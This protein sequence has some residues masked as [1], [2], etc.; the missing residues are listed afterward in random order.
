MPKMTPADG[1]SVSV[2]LPFPTSETPDARLLDEGEF[3]GIS[4]DSSVAWVDAKLDEGL[5]L[6][7]SDGGDAVLYVIEGAAVAF[8]KWLN[9]GF[10]D[11]ASVIGASTGLLVGDFSGDI[12]GNDVGCRE[13]L[14]DGALT[15]DVDG[16][17][18]GSEV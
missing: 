1:A 5:K 12:D 8:N 6:A 3:E 10:V 7:K 13:G 11:G 4:V 17:W 14:A 2:S 16:S 18:L 9:D 15:G